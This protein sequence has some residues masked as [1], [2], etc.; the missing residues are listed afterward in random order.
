MRRPSHKWA[1][2]NAG[3]NDA[4]PRAWRCRPR[5]TES[6]R[7]GQVR[8]QHLMQYAQTRISDT[9]VHGGHSPV[10]VACPFAAQKDTTMPHT[11]ASVMHARRAHTASLS[12]K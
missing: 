6:M 10:Y 4:I 2:C 12:N 8:L 11:A 9:Q 3:T 7:N 5:V 1:H